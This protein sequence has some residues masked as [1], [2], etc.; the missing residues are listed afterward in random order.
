[1]IVSGNLVAL[2]RHQTHLAAKN[3]AVEGKLVNLTKVH[4]THVAGCTDAFR[5]MSEKIVLAHEQA[6][7]ALTYSQKVCTRMINVDI[8][9]RCCCG[10]LAGL[11]VRYQST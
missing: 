5:A 6:V 7:E 10:R 2:T 8:L 1:M 4:V 11:V 3:A 9:V